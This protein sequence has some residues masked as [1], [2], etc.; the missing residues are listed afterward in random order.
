MEYLKKLK[1][2]HFLKQYSLGIIHI[3]KYVK[4]EWWWLVVILCLEKGHNTNFFIHWWLLP[5]QHKSDSQ[6]SAFEYSKQLDVIGGHFP[7]SK[8]GRR[9]GHTHCAA[10]RKGKHAKCNSY[11]VGL[12]AFHRRLITSTLEVLF[13][14]FLLYITFIPYSDGSSLWTVCHFHK[15]VHFKKHF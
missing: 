11:N 3:L 7:M 6:G 5:R 13:L 14:S 12:C 9:K 4:Y 1:Q 2:S 15:T 8:E 10:C